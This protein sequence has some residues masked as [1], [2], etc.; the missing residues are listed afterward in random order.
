MFY[1]VTGCVYMFCIVTGYVYMFCIVTGYVYMFCIVTVVRVH[2]WCC[3][4]G[5]REKKLEKHCSK[6]LTHVAFNFYNS[7][8]WDNNEI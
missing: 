4:S 7:C 2:V 1:I 8:G 6:Q 5:T 3:E